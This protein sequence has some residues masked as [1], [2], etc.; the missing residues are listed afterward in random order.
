MRLSL[1]H[2]RRF[3]IAYILTALVVAG[4]T[5]V[6]LLLRAETS[7]RVRLLAWISA[8]VMMV[9]APRSYS[10]AIF[11]PVLFGLILSA[12]VAHTSLWRVARTAALGALVTIAVVLLVVTHVWNIF[13]VSA[14]LDPDSKFLDVR[15]YAAHEERLLLYAAAVRMF[16]ESPLTGVGPDRFDLC[17]R[18]GFEFVSGDARDEALVASLLKSA[19]VVVPLAAVVGAPACDRDPE[20]A[21]ALNRDAVR[22]VNRMRSRDQLLV[23][24]NT[25]S[26]YGTRS[27]EGF[28]TEETPLEPI[29]VYG[30]T[31]CE[32]ELD[33][34]D[35]PNALTLRLATVF[36][37]SP[38]MR[39]DLLVNHFVHAAVTEG[40]LVLFEKDF[41]RNFVHV[42][43]VADYV[44][45]NQRLREAGFEARRSIDEGIEELL[46]AYRMLPRSPW[47]NV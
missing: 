13:P 25:N 7:R 23:F 3:A 24:P 31:K 29:S 26:G 40:Y 43:D 5:L 18:P 47:K 8:V 45:S 32:A 6:C 27:G 33:V 12:R 11:A 38:R 15:L 14:R 35:S 1:A 22:M 42:R 4:A 36:G 9:V 28:C 39:L 19:D 37:V 20:L 21:V 44:V 16:A 2:L 41:R 17:G 30:R 46:R 10:R 34:L